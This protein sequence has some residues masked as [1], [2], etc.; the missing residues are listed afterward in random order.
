MKQLKL[1]LLLTL[2]MSMVCIEATSH[3]IE[4]ANSNGVTIYYIWTNNRTAL[5]VSYCGSSPYSSSNKYTG[6]V[7]IPASVTYNGSTYPVTSIGSYAFYGCSGLTSVTIPNSVTSICSSAFNGCSGLTSVTIGNSVTSIGSSAFNGCSGLTSVTIPNS[8]TSIGNSA[9]NGCSSLTSLNIPNSVTSIGDGAFGRCSCL[10]SIMVAS[11]NTTFDSR[12]N[13]NAIIETASNKLIAGCKNTMIPSSV[14]SIGEYAFSGC[15]GLTSVTIP[16]SVTSIGSEAFGGCSGLKKVNISD[17]VAWCNIS[18]G[19]SYS[20]PL[21]YAHHLYLNGSEIKDLVIPSSVN[22]LNSYSFYGGYFSSVFVPSSIKM[23]ESGKFIFGYAHIG[24]ININWYIP[25]SCL[26]GA[27]IDCVV[28]NE[29]AYSAGT[30]AFYNATINEVIIP[31]SEE[32]YSY[33]SS[34]DYYGIFGNCTIKKVTVDRNIKDT[35]YYNSAR[36]AFFDCKIDTMIIGPNAI[37]YAY[38]YL[39]DG[40]EINDLYFNGLTEINTMAYYNDGS[41]YNT[42]IK[43]LHLSDGLTTIKEKAFYNTDGAYLIKNHLILPQSLVS[44]GSKGLYAFEDYISVSC[45]AN[46]PPSIEDDTF[47]DNTYKNTLYVPIGSKSLY[48]NAKGWNKF[49]EIVEI[50]CKDQNITFADIN[51]KNM[52][53]KLWDIDGD[54]ELTCNE[55]ALVKSLYGFANTSFVDEYAKIYTSFEELEHFTGLEEIPYM[56]F[57]QCSNLSS[58][59]IPNNIKKIGDYAFQGCEKLSSIL[60]PNSVTSIGNCAFQYCSGLTSVTVMMKTPIEITENTFGYRN[61]AILYVPYGCKAAYESAEYWQEF[62][63]IVELEPDE[64]E[65]I[66]VTDIAQLDNAIYIEPV[67]GL[68]GTTIDMYVKMKNT[69]TP[70]GCSFMLTLP[71]GLRLLK[72]EDGDVVYQLGNRARKMSLN[73]KDWDN[74]SYDFALTPSTGTAT[75][76]GNDDVVVTF[77]LLIPEDM[78]AGDYKLMLT[79]CLIQSKADGTTQDYPLSDV[80]TKLTVEDYIL[81][82]VNGDRNVTPSDAIMTLYHYF[83]VE[84]TGFNVKAADVNVDGNVTPADAIET[85]YIY[86]NTG[87]QGNARQMQQTLDPQ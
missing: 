55:A 24:S 68:V 75:I 8:V 10:K 4:V 60:I 65:Q 51:V 69:L 28:I 23:F 20:N 61:N 41:Y 46:T 29:N 83:N 50:P 14:T 48:E 16:N 52:C 84:Q 40:C 87:S 80:V 78:E 25:N 18:F 26:S 74:G 9:F 62:K 70:V 17:V 6:S 34:S 64:P 45:F 53:V 11:G 13:C 71:D 63:E 57:S 32:A 36:G 3:D 22:K 2:L 86:F 19:N 31:Y 73:M 82:D 56:L 12:S 5:S 1:T 21:Y 38:E 7:V 72:D 47:A 37:N 42:K 30:Y 67:E 66:E 15:S 49:A 44:V 76:S 39:Y 54:G 77:Q 85:L 79:K 58:I 59:R 81:G 27:V 43:N 35:S 33:N